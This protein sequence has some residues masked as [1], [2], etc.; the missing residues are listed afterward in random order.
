[1]PVILD[2]KNPSLPPVFRPLR[3]FER[4][5]AAKELPKFDVDVRFG[6]TTVFKRC[7]RHVRYR[8][9]SGAKA[10]IAALRICV[11]SRLA[12]ALRARAL[13]RLSVSRYCC[14]RG[15]ATDHC[16]SAPPGRRHS[17]SSSRDRMR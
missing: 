1:M 11:T 14:P 3:S 10:D 13:S 4:S 6:S 15:S 8:P 16:H 5:E 17:I 2:N 9:N 7:L 12:T